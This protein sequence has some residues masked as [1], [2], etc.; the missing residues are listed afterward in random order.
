MLPSWVRVLLLAIAVIDD[1]LAITLIAIL[2]TA[3]LAPLWLAGGLLNQ[4]TTHLTTVKRRTHR[5]R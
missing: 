2:F 4:S 3:D 1:L 5:V